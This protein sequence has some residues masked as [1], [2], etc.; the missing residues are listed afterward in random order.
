MGAGAIIL[1]ARGAGGEWDYLKGRAG[2]PSIRAFAK[3][4]PYSG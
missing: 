3:L 1:P 2:G 4:S